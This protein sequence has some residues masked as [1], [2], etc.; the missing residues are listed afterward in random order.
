MN[1]SGAHK[2]AMHGSLHLLGVDLVH[3]LKLMKLKYAPRASASL[4]MF[5][6]SEKTEIFGR[7]LVF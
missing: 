5:A 6:A 3:V 2:R 1:G 4:R 7:M